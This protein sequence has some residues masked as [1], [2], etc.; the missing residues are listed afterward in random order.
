[1]EMV[2]HQTVDRDITCV[3]PGSSGKRS[4][5]GLANFRFLTGN[6]AAGEAGCEGDGHLSAVAGAR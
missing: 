6:P 3:L 1:M 5:H 4:D 2:G